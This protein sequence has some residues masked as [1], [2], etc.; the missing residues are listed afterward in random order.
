M[1]TDRIKKHFEKEA[2][3]YDSIIQKLIPYYNQMIDA[4]VSTIP[5]P[6]SSTFSVIDLGCGT[7]TI[8]KAVKDRFP[9]V[10]I[11]CVDIADEML[12]IANEK[13]EGNVTCVQADFND[14]SFPQKYD[15]IVSSL[16]L[17]HLETDQDKLE[18]YEK[19]YSA[20]NKD[21][22]FINLDVV[23]GSDDI[24]QD[25]YMQK[26]KEYMSKSVSEAEINDKWLPNYYA[27]DRPMKMTSHLEQ[28][29]QCGFSS[30]DIVYKFY[31]YAVYCGK[32]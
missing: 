27:E 4:M 2:R 21:G 32:K 20:L 13:L 11:T 8:S 25:A 31:N 15:L 29:S 28:L 3:E 16:A 7:G 14:F 26:W 17:H 9:N 10:E 18:F 19:I 23:L 30:I 24:L 5:F 22:I 12:Q 1:R 6:Q